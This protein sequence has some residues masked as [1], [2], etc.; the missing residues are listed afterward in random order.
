VQPK[1]QHVLL[2][3][4]WH[5]SKKPHLPRLIA[6]IHV[7]K[8]WEGLT[9]TKKETPTPFTYNNFPKIKA[10]LFKVQTC[11]FLRIHVFPLST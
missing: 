4:F 6:T 8:D 3:C 2:F 10:S 11:H 7:E 5:K 1:V 9:T